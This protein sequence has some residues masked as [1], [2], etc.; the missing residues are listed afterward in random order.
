M[1]RAVRCTAAVTAVL[2]LAGCAAQAGGAAPS[3]SETR[4]PQA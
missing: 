2:M 1:R 3:P 4:L